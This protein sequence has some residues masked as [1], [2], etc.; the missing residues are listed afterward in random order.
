[1]ELNS[2]VCLFGSGFYSVGIG[3]VRVLF[4]GKRIR[5]GFIRWEADPSFFYRVGSGQSI[6]GSSTL[7]VHIVAVKFA[8]SH[9]VHLAKARSK[10]SF[11]SPLY[12]CYYLY[13]LVGYLVVQLSTDIRPCYQK[14]RKR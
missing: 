5:P 9:Y 4:G 2:G 11:F 10:Y 12:I 6:S 1:M 3:S 14:S 7:A 8:L 13:F